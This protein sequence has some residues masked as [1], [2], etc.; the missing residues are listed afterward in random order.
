MPL[1]RFTEILN[2]ASEQQV[3]VM[4]FVSNKGCIQIHSGLITKLVTMENWF[5]VLDPQFNLHLNMDAID[6]IWQVR[7]PST[8]G[9]VNALEVYDK[10]GNLIVQLLG[11]ENRVFLN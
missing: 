11:N 6:Q 2:Q 4:V 3:P 7:K 10:Q 5:N 1:E 9:D 8:D